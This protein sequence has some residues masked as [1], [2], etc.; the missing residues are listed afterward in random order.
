MRGRAILRQDICRCN[1]S[2][3]STWRWH[4]FLASADHNISLLFI[5]LK[6]V[7]VTCRRAKKGHRSQIPNRS[8]PDSVEQGGCHHFYTETVVARFDRVIGRS[9]WKVWIF[10]FR[11]PAL[12]F[13]A[14]T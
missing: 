2:S 14:W 12:Q 4:R 10:T 6:K 7:A 8:P 1:A 13:R 9:G 5:I 11:L 3:E